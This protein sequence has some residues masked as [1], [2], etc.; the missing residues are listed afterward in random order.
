MDFFC[1]DFVM[2]NIQ[3]DQAGQRRSGAGNDWREKAHTGALIS[4]SVFEGSVEGQACEL[5]M[6]QIECR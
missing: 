5:I 6:R 3:V 1:G 2:G 4:R